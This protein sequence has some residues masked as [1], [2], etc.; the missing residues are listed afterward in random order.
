MIIRPIP[1][2][3][4][5]P[6]YQELHELYCYFIE[7]QDELLARAKPFLSDPLFGELRGRY[8]GV[9][10][11]IGA[12]LFFLQQVVQP[13]NQELLTTWREA[14]DAVSNQGTR[15]ERSVSECEP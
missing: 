3:K 8:S 4:V 14:C 5:D 15:L 1:N 7:M 2:S 13:N 9:G 11:D 12:L 10:A 6:K